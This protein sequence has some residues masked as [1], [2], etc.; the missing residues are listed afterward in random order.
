LIRII[1]ST[2]EGEKLEKEVETDFRGY[3]DKKSEFESKNQAYE[4]LKSKIANLKFDP[5]EYEELNSNRRKLNVEINKLREN[6][7]SFFSR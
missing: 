5:N 7:Q 6:G 1:N 4:S 3:E 2:K